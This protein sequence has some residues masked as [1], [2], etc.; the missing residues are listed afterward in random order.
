MTVG[1]G[2]RHEWGKLRE[3]VV[4]DAPLG[5]LL[6][7]EG[8]AV[9]PVPSLLLPRDCM[10][11]AGAH[12]IE[13]SLR[14]PERQ[15]ER[16]SLRAHAQ[17]MA[18]RR[19]A[20]WSAVPLGSPNGADGPYLE[21]GDVLLNG[22]EV[23]V[24][25]S[26]RGS[27]MAGIDWL[28]ALL[29]ASPRVIPVAMRSDVAHLQDVLALVRPG[30]LICCPEKLIDGLP[31][32]LRSWDAITISREEATTGAAQLVVLDEGR[33]VA[34]TAHARVIGE[35]RARRMDVMAIPFDAGLRAAHLALWREGETE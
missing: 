23:Y 26:G 9:R 30:L 10:I 16:F 7:R 35:L 24:G 2:A 28:E 15:A 11:V 25:M 31:M 27:D 14:R 29:G 12:L 21:G 19:R 20:R 17:E 1:F 5:A 34:T 13:G 33:A 32:S 6:A 3:V 18:L 22:G 8:V 4:G